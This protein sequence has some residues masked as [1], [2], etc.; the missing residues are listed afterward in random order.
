[1]T[2]DYQ[3]NI[4]DGSFTQ[5]VENVYVDEITAVLVQ[6][7]E[8]RTTL[9][10]VE[11]NQETIVKCL[12]ELQCQLK[13]IME[14]MPT[15]AENPLPA[16]KS[17]DKKSDES[18]QYIH[19]KIGTCEELAEFE[20]KLE[21]ASFRKI[22]KDHWTLQMGTDIGLGRFLLRLNSINR[23]KLIYFSLY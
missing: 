9:E 21:N 4:N 8:M 6:M 18:S 14:R 7:G 16:Q 19:T 10:R 22:V 13:F 11:K 3:Q 12:T 5:Q 2:S 15:V 1:M 17:D 23:S 20:K